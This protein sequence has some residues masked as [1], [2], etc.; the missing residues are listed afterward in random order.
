MAHSE[1]SFAPPPCKVSELSA[2][3]KL[4]ALNTAIEA[5]EN[6]ADTPLRLAAL[7]RLLEEI[8]TAMSWRPAEVTGVEATAVESAED[9]ALG[10]ELAELTQ[11]LDKAVAVIDG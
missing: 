7:K 11:R 3:V 5:H 1:V 8:Q 10:R 4:L 9:E 6:D 2:Q